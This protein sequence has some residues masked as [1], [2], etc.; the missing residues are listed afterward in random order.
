MPGEALSGVRRLARRRWTGSAGRRA[1]RGSDSRAPGRSRTERT[2]PAEKL[3]IARWDFLEPAAPP[4]SPWVGDRHRTARPS[5]SRQHEPGALAA[6]RLVAEIVRQSGFAAGRL[7]PRARRSEGAGPAQGCWP[8]LV[9]STS[10]AR[11]GRR[12]TRTQTGEEPH[13][14]AWPTPPWPPLLPR[15]AL[16]APATPPRLSAPR[17]RADARGASSPR[18]GR[19]HGSAPRGISRGSRVEPRCPARCARPSRWPDWSARAG[20][21]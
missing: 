3:S 15:D 12:E 6:L 18:T 5:P 10:P 14:P 17:W 2:T 1:P 20:G 21:S 9:P 11:Q 7:D 19:R 13:P 8:A 16:K 4:T